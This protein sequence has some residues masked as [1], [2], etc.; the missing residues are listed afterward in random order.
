LLATHNSLYGI[1]SRMADVPRQFKGFRVDCDE[2]NTEG[3]KPY[4]VYGAILV[5]LD[6]I[7]EVQREIKEW[8]H[9]EGIH[10][11]VKWNKL[12]CAPRLAKYKS[13]VDLAFTLARRRERLHFKAIVLDRRSPNIA[14]IARATRN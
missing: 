7:A 12:H 9:R 1:R 8:R 6:H 13:L 5:S 2:S 10:D 4:P 3:G 11:E 14:R